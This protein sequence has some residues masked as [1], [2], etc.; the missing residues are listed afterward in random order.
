MR[1]KRIRRFLSRFLDPSHNTAYISE[2]S[3]FMPDRGSRV[4]HCFIKMN[5]N[6]TL[7]VSSGAKVSNVRFQINDRSSVTIAPGCELSDLDI[8]VWGSSSLVFEDQCQVHQARLV[9][10]K[11]KVNIGHATLISRGEQAT[12]PSIIVADGS[13]SIG[14]HNNLK[15]S[16]WIRFGGK[17]NIGQ[18]N[19][20]NEGTEVRCDE[21]VSIGSY[22]MISYQ[23]DIWDTNTHAKYSLEE[24]KSMFVNDFPAIGR[25][26]RKPDT[27]PVIIGDGNWIGKLT[28]ILKGS[29]LCN[30][31]IV[32]TRAVI[33][34]QTLEDNTTF[35]SMKGDS[36]R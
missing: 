26:S 36:I 34:N 27:K 1:F 21:A 14:D 4:D 20:V 25:E 29:T 17:V 15:G 22:N 30:N 18:Y 5:G 9:I 16:F 35:V 19:C 10:E 2:G 7:T 12:G 8:C 6:S 3:S 23:C 13:L 33:S 24:K 31:V 11:G 28:C 32:G